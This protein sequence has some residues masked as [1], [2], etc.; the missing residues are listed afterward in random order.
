[1]KYRS[2]IIVLLLTI[3]ELHAM[4]ENRSD[5]LLLNKVFVHQNTMENITD[6]IGINMYSK[7]Y[8]NTHRRNFGLWLI[9]SMYAIADGQRQ[10]M[11]EQYSRIYYTGRN[12]DQIKPKRQLFYTTIPRQHTIMNTLDAYMRPHIYSPTIFGKQILSPFC[13]ENKRFYKY[14]ITGRDKKTTYISFK[15]RFSKNTQLIVGTGIIDNETGQILLMQFEGE[16]DMVSF[17]TRLMNNKVGNVILPQMSHTWTDFKF[18]GNHITSSFQSVY[19]S[20]ITLPDTLEIEGDRHAFDTIRPVSLSKDEQAIYD[21]YDS[22]HAPKPDTTEAQQEKRHDLLK[23]IGWNVIGWHLVSSHRAHT[24]NY[25][26]KLSPLL[27]PQYISYSHSKGLSYKMKLNMEYYLNKNAQ[28]NMYSRVGYNFKF[29]Q[30]YFE[31]PLQWVY[32]V[33]RNNYAELEWTHGDRISNSTVVD[34]LEEEYGELEE[35]KEK[36]FDMFND[37]RLHFINSMQLTPQIRLEAGAVYHSRRSVVKQDMLRYDKPWKYRSLAPMVGIK[38]TPWKKG[39]VF[40]IDY[41]RGIKNKWFDQK[42]ER[43]ETDASYM[44]PLPSTQTLNLRMGYGFYTLRSGNYFMDYT[45]FRNDNLPGGWDDD[46]TGD[47]QL[48]SRRMYNQSRFYLRSNVSYE[49]PILL[50]SF[51]PWLGEYMERERFYLSSLLIEHHKPYQE[52]GYSFTTRFVSL[53]AFVSFSSFTPIEFGTKI[54]LELFRRW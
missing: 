6:T 12:N 33:K 10:F 3:C 32:D 16:Y 20:P 44:H 18:L 27:E 35:F 49:T 41:E 1:M 28:L 11:A 39:P 5:S 7:I 52:L 24:E 14:A 36:D 46:W 38:L 15:P 47:F 34:Q 17:Q 30:F 31:V 54:S 8:Y 4:A 19:D 53:A 25:Y 21:Q 43:W 51:I 2:V 40:S 13:R 48:L 23:D 42:Y 9:P 29:K 26:V 37:E 50:S 22:L 45:N